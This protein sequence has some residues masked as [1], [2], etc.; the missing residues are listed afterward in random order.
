[1]D[2]PNQITKKRRT[3]KI[4]KQNDWRR[5]NEDGLVKSK[6]IKKEL[7]KNLL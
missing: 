6:D 4:P 5:R 2:P 1:M 7:K 3:M